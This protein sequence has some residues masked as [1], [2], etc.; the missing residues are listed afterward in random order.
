MNKV[1][2]AG[3]PTIKENSANVNGKITIEKSVDK[4]LVSGL[5]KIQ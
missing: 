1:D 4:L 3:K 5:I 2:R